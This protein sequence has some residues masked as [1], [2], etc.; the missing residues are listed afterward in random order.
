MPN[1]L[2]I[3]VLGLLRGSADGPI[4]VAVLGLI[5]LSAICGTLRRPPLKRFWFAVRRHAR[6]KERL[7]NGGAV[8]E[9]GR[10][11][12]TKRRG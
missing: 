3:D 7:L 6:A 2:S 1:H 5:T 4:A 12:T 10:E 9:T 11:R 8:T